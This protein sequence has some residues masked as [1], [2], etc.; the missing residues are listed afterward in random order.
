MWKCILIILCYCIGIYF[1]WLNPNDANY[2]FIFY[3]CFSIPVV[4]FV[5]K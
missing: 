4:F 3:V 5:I 1:L 2:K